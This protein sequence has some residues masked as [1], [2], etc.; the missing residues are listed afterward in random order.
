MP[1]RRVAKT[2]NAPYPGDNTSMSFPTASPMSI[3]QAITRKPYA[4]VRHV[5][6]NTVAGYIPAPQ[7]SVVTAGQ[8]LHSADIVGIGDGTLRV[9]ARF[10]GGTSLPLINLCAELQGPALAALAA[11][12]AALGDIPV[13]PY[14]SVIPSDMLITTPVRITSRTLGPLT[15]D[16]PLLAQGTDYRATKPSKT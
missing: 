2:G 10:Y 11:S 1:E 13:A 6:Y 5:F 14:P 7:E 3:I 8:R 4:D 15:S 9:E 12:V 16:R